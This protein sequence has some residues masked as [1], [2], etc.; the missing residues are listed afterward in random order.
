[1][2]P[3]NG[4]HMEKRKKEKAPRLLSLLAHLAEP[5]PIVHCL[6]GVTPITSSLRCCCHEIQHFCSI[7]GGLAPL[8][9]SFRTD[10][11]L[12]KS[13][14]VAL[15]KKDESRSEKRV[16][17]CMCVRVL[18][19]VKH[20]AKQDNSSHSGDNFLVTLCTG[21]QGKHTHGHVHTISLHGWK[22]KECADRDEWG[23]MKYWK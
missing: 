9:C 12:Y 20:A 13:N 22:R 4:K 8:Y 15:E 19:G 7:A 2:P 16:R 23:A 11:Q 17:V 14:S 6:S 1:M 21:T 5:R 18:P 3:F 10:W